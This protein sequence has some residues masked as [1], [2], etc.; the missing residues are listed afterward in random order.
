MVHVDAGRTLCNLVRDCKGR[1]L[2]YQL[3]VNTTGLVFEG[4]GG[5]NR[6]NCIGVGLQR[7]PTAE[8]GRAQK[9]GLVSNVLDT[10]VL[11][12]HSLLNP[13]ER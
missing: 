6:L 11:A 1:G 4:F 12:K 3:D 10:L 2:K 9:R 8:T 13:K 5:V 7:V